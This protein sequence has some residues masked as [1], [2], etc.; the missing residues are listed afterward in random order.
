MHKYLSYRLYVTNKR[1]YICQN[2]IN[3]ELWI[4]TT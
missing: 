2:K 1:P 4:Y 3:I